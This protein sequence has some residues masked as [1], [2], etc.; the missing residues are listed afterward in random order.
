MISNHTISVGHQ[1]QPA[2]FTNQSEI[3]DLAKCT[4]R[5][6]M[7]LNCPTDNKCQAMIRNN[8]PCYKPSSELSVSRNNST[9][10]RA[11]LYPCLAFR[12]YLHEENPVPSSTA[13]IFHRPVKV[14]YLAACIKRVN[15]Y[16]QF[17][18]ANEELQYC[19]LLYTQQSVAGFSHTNT[20]LSTAGWQPCLVFRTCCTQKIPFE[21]NNNSTYMSPTRKTQALVTCFNRKDSLVVYNRQ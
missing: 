7:Y 10:S 17:P 12:P 6:N 5:M 21:V 11:G 16:L 2:Y 18:T 13:G 14:E 1:Q 3:Q 4:I 9:D 19:L 8:P 15:M 20:R